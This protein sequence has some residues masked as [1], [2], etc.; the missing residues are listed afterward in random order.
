MLFT[1][2]DCDVFSYFWFSEDI[3]TLENNLIRLQTLYKGKLPFWKF[4]FTTPLFWNYIEYKKNNNELDTFLQEHE[5]DEQYL[6]DLLYYKS[7]K[8]NEYPFLHIITELN[9]KFSPSI[10]SNT[11][12]LT[13][14]MYNSFFQNNGFYDKN[15]TPQIGD[16][17][18]SHPIY[19]YCLNTRYSLDS[20]I[21]LDMIPTDVS[22]LPSMFITSVIKDNIFSTDMFLNYD[23]MTSAEKAWYNRC[24]TYIVYYTKDTKKEV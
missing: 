14:D 9:L 22:V 15:Y 16:R 2:L 8:R 12:Q 10:I 18:Y 21:S 7:F 6:C 24:I 17:F 5:L 4:L 11:N 13:Q 19:I 3:T 20:N 1:K 23:I